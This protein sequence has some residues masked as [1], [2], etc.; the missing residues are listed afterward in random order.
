MSE[1]DRA[2]H[3]FSRGGRTTVVYT[4]RRSSAGMPDCLSCSSGNSLL[5]VFRVFST[6]CTSHVRLLV[7]VM[8]SNFASRVPSMRIIGKFVLVLDK[9]ITSSVVLHLLIFM[10]IWI[11]HIYAASAAYWKFG[12]WESDPV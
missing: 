1:V 8:Q 2:G 10:S 7:M 6:T 9:S 11:V 3:A 4:V 5:P 12:A